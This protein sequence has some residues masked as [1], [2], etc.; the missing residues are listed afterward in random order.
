MGNSESDCCGCNRPTSID[1]EKAKRKRIIQT[2]TAVKNGDD[3]NEY[4][5]VIQIEWNDKSIDWNYHKSNR[6]LTSLKTLVSYSFEINDNFSLTY[7]NL[8]QTNVLNIENNN[9]LNKAVK[10]AENKNGNKLTIS[11]V[12]YITKHIP[13]HRFSVDDV[14]RIIKQWVLNDVDYKKY[15][16]KTATIFHNHELNG[17]QIRHLL[18]VNITNIIKDEMLEFVTLNT[19]NIMVNSINYHDVPSKSAKQIG[20]DIFN[21]PFQRL[22][23][24]IYTEKID[25]KKIIDIFNDETNDIFE[26]KTGWKKDE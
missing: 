18:A 13:L 12:D 23:D 3:P 21:A 20:F 6:S 25:G 24:Y 1:I 5:L 19:L 14:I 16:S 8:D 10:Y 9:D 2:N 11:V 15:R 4:D 22:I 26:I 7:I 17:E